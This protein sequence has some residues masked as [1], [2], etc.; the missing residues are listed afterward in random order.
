M[1]KSKIQDPIEIPSPKPG[2]LRGRLFGSQR[3]QHT[4]TEAD[5][6]GGQTAKM[7]RKI[8]DRKIMERSIFLSSF[9]RMGLALR[10]TRFGFRASGLFRISPA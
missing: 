6:G 7:D 5:F 4:Q 8:E 10:C 9:R 3:Q 1:P 2:M